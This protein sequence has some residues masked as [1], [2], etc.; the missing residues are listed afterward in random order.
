MQKK[1][2]NLSYDSQNY[3]KD[4][5]PFSI[6]PSDIIIGNFINNIIILLSYCES[7]DL[8]FLYE[9]KYPDKEKL[10]FLKLMIKYIKYMNDSRLTIDINKIYNILDILIKKNVTNYNA[11]TLSLQFRQ[12]SAILIKY[13]LIIYFYY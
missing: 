12:I 5:K 13:I 10:Y 9:Y 2:K 4:I 3:Y 6:K 1:K 11:L 8:N 7:L